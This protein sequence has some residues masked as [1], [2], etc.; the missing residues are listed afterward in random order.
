MF[1][2]DQVILLLEPRASSDLAASLAIA[3]K[4]KKRIDNAKAR[5]QLEVGSVVKAAGYRQWP[6][7]LFWLPGVARAA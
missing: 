4:D 6:K 2:L 3:L 5:A 1:A 7:R